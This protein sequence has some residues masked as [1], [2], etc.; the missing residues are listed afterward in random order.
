MARLDL[1][2]EVDVPAERFPAEIEANAYFIVAEAL[3]NVVKHAHAERAE[4]TA[5]VED[6]MLRV[7]VRDD[8]IGGA[9]PAGHGLVGIGDRAT[10]LGGRLD[11][12]ARPAAAHR[13]RH[14]P[15]P[16]D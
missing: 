5:P 15:A 1:P 11:S 2:V 10:A 8:G 14:A 7:E 3:T 13:G 6:G 12:R 16:D 4:V 9:D